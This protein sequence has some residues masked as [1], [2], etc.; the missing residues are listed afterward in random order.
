ML[1]KQLTV[2]IRIM[3]IIKYAPVRFEDIASKV[4][5]SRRTVAL[6]CTELR[7][8]NLLIGVPGGGGGVKRINKNK[9][10][11]RQIALAMGHTT[12]PKSILDI[13]VDKWHEEIVP[14]AEKEGESCIKKSTKK[15]LPGARS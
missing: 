4:F 8:A 3:S 1:S 11:I 10:T 14:L 5:R 9:I 13:D 6:F 12:G 7:H 2:A 15:I